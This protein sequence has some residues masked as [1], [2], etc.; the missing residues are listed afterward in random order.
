MFL[1]WSPTWKT[2]TQTKNSRESK[3]VN[4]KDYNGRCIF[5]PTSQCERC[6]VS[7]CRAPSYYSTLC[8]FLIEFL[9]P[10]VQRREG[11]CCLQVLRLPPTVHR[12]VHWQA[13]MIVY[14]RRWF[15]VI[16][17]FFVTFAKVLVRVLSLNH[18]ALPKHCA[19]NCQQRTDLL[20]RPVHML[21]L[22]R[23]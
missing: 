12:L 21:Y 16:F 23:W 22:F 15:F 2:K 19:Q 11:Q 10:Q 6:T 1:K 5:H 17:L 14:E 4:S 20:N 8:W 7:S 18:T 3:F 13:T 9:S